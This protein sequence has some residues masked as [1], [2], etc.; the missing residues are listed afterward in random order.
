MFRNTTRLLR[1]ASISDKDSPQPT[2]ARHVN[3][4]RP[5]AVAYLRLSY[6]TISSRNSV[7]LHR[8]QRYSQITSWPP[9]PPSGDTLLPTSLLDWWVRS[10]VEGV[11]GNVVV[12]SLSL[13][14]WNLVPFLA[15]SEDEPVD[16]VRL[17]QLHAINKV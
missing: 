11:E 7:E 6:T 17:V 15:E 2:R 9:A 8:W 12:E 4:P 16:S 5:G 3:Y 1:C 14:L 13:L 10:E